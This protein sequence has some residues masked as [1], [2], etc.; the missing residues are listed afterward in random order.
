MEVRPEVKLRYRSVR[1]VPVNVW[2]SY[3]APSTEGANATLPA[4]EVVE[5]VAAPPGAEW[6]FARPERYAELEA[7]V[8][9]R[10]DRE[11]A[12][13]SGYVLC[14]DLTRLDTDFQLIPGTP[15]DHPLGDLLDH[16][17]AV[18]SPVV[19]ELVRQ[20]A[21]AIPRARLWDMIDWHHPPPPED[22]EAILR[23]QLEEIG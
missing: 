5:I 2:I 20:I 3:A 16:G 13:Y 18:F 23:W 10:E 7:A 6:A 21:G 11:A 22:L 12:R 1:D 19:D 14:I 15:G 9:P 4:N 8:V 17:R